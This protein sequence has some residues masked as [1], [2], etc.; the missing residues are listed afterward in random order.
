MLHVSALLSHHQAYTSKTTVFQ[1]CL[2]VFWAIALGIPFA[3]QIR[4]TVCMVLGAYCCS[5]SGGGVC[6]GESSGSTH[7]RLWKGLVSISV[8]LNHCIRTRLLV[9]LNS[10][11]R[12]GVAEFY[13]QIFVRMLVS[14]I[15]GGSG[16]W[17]S[18]PLWCILLPVGVVGFTRLNSLWGCPSYWCCVFIFGVMF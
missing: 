18:V 11:V 15:S 12:V 13:L 3:L 6:I 17:A 1:F 10:N 5:Y 9:V 14:Q 8:I 2:T 16:S 7:L 4:I